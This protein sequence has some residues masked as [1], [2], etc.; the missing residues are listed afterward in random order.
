MPMIDRRG[1]IEHLHGQFTLDWQGLHG[2]THWARVRANG[3]MLARQNMANRHVVEL[4][5]F[6]HDA[7]RLSEH[8]DAGHGER[9]AELAAQLRGRYFEATNAEMDLLHDACTHHSDGLTIGEITVLTCWD[10]DRLDLERVG[11]TPRAL[12]TDAAK[13]SA[14]QLKARTR[15]RAWMDRQ[16]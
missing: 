5:A 11:T 12:C 13:D 6:F 16:R 2:I 9:G 15:A 1:L 4:F 3:L 7:R 14:N 8:G 10:A